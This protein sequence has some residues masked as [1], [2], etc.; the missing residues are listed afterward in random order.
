MIKTALIIISAILAV[1][2][3]S[4]VLHTIRLLVLMPKQLPSGTTVIKLCGDEQ[5]RQLHYAGAAFNWSGTA[6]C[7]KKLAVSDLPPGEYLEECREAAQQYDIMLCTPEQLEGYLKTT[8][9]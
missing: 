6:F 9:V 7:G 2:G 5:L 3:L 1:L 8:E 4:E